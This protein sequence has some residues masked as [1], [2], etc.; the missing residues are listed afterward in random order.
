[1]IDAKGTVEED[2]RSS[3]NE[4]FDF[5]DDSDMVP[6]VGQEEGLQNMETHERN[7]RNVDSEECKE[8]EKS[9]IIRFEFPQTEEDKNEIQYAETE[10]LQPMQNHCI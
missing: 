6:V 1:M 10:T 8:E 2:Q 7:H 5:A 9:N 3:T 4:K